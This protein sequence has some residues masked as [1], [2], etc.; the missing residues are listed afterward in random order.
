M[1]LKSLRLKLSKASINGASK[2]TLYSINPPTKIK[3]KVQWNA[4]IKKRTKIPNEISKHENRWNCC[5]FWRLGF[6]WLSINLTKLTINWK[7]SRCIQQKKKQNSIVWIL[8]GEWFKESKIHWEVFTWFYLSLR[9]FIFYF[10]YWIFF[11]VI[12]YKITP[13]S[14]LLKDKTLIHLKTKL[15]VSIF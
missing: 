3:Q 1:S 6:I 5:Y 11:K 14:F 10:I 4:S 9:I 12:L 15:C 8:I 13:Y 2:S 7:V